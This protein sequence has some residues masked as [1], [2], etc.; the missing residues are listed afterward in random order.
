LE[1]GIQIQFQPGATYRTGDYWLIPA[2]VATGDVE[3]P[4]L[5]DAQGKLVPDENGQPQPKPLPPRGVEHHYAP[6]AVIDVDNEGNISS[7]VTDDLRRKFSPAA[8]E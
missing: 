8:P 4:K 7:P 1:D 5:R 2:R 6:L 3:W